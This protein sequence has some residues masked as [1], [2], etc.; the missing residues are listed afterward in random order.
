MRAPNEDKGRNRV[1]FNNLAYRLKA[2]AGSLA[3]AAA[4]FVITPAY[5]NSSASTD[6]AAPLRAAQAA[7]PAATGDEQFRKL[8]SSWE[9]LEK[10]NVPAL[11]AVGE[12]AQ[13]GRNPLSAGARA[14]SFQS[15]ASSFNPS[16]PAIPSR[17]PL[18]GLRLTSD[19][20]MRFHP[21]LGRM[22]NHEGV[23]LG[24]PTGTA[25][26]A[27]ADGMVEKAEWFGGYGL[28][29]Q[30]EHGGSLETRYGHMSRLNVAPGQVV[31]KG[32]IIGFVGT[33]GRS[34]GPHLHYEVRVGGVAVNP[35]PYMQGE[36]TGAPV[37]L[38]A[39]SNR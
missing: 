25:V 39:N 28:C 11:A 21:I 22:R 8:F 38:A 19:F 12:A 35:V 14:G 4:I 2:A 10:S 30:L 27:T 23:D 16:K 18:A 3:G 1:V 32:D 37:M 9:S 31:H 20:G 29:V 5:A 17:A 15:F 33:T 36:D 34:T 7:K 6:I 24:A 13:A 26:Y